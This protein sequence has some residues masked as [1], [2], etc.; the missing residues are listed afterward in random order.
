MIIK[1]IGQTR[2][3]PKTPKFAWLRDLGIHFKMKFAF[4]VD[5]C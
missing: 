5:W 1:K 2:I 3:A 4:P